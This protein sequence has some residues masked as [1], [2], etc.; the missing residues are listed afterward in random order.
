VKREQVV[1][2]ERGLRLLDRGAIAAPARQVLVAQ[3]LARRGLVQKDVHARVGQ[4]RGGRVGPRGRHARA[5]DLRLR[6]IERVLQGLARDR[7]DGGDR[8]MVAHDVRLCRFRVACGRYD[9]ST[10]VGVPI[11]GVL[12]TST[13]RVHVS[14]IAAMLSAWDSPDGLGP[15][16]GLPARK[17]AVSAAVSA[18][19]GL[20]K[21]LVAEA[22]RARPRARLKNLIT[23]SSRCD[24][25]PPY[26]DGSLPTQEYVLGEISQRPCLPR[27][28]AAPSGN[29]RRLRQPQSPPCHQIASLPAIQPSHPKTL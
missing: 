1:Q 11:A 25:S 21:W 26:L 16:G 28:S 9:S 20:R 17:N 27:R 6:G 5:G 12:M 14:R 8:E 23:R 15:P 19:G 2:V 10:V 4:V 18:V 3:R 29:S 13:V 7:G 24:S 22:D